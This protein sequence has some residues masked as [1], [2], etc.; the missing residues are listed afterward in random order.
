MKIFNKSIKKSNGFTLIEL[1]VV[2]A[3][4][5]LLTTIAVVSLGIARSKGKAARAAGDLRQIATVLQMYVN[6]NGGYP[7]FDH[8]FSDTWETTWSAPYMKWPKNPYGSRYHF[9]HLST[10]TYSI[11]LESVALADAQVLANLINNGS[12]SSGILR[13]WSG[14]DPVRLEWGGVDQNLPVPNPETCL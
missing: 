11:S 1:L 4:I 7:C 6:D 9:E 13:I 5:G 8:N 2:I 14:T 3:V 12:L 10:F